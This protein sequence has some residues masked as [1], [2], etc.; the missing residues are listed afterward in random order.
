MITVHPV[1]PA[2]WI[3]AMATLLITAVGHTFGFVKF[4]PVLSL[5]FYFLFSE[6]SKFVAEMTYDGKNK[7]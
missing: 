7:N 3:A 5:V 1:A 6:T 4:D 2:L